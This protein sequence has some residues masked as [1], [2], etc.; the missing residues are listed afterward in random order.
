M[1]GEIEFFLLKIQVRDA[2][3][4]VDILRILLKNDLVLINRLFG[5]FVIVRSIG[6]RDVLLGKRSGKVEPGVDQRRVESYR[7][8]KVIDRL[9]VFGIFV[10][11]HALVQVIARL[12]LGATGSGEECQSSG[13]NPQEPVSRFHCFMNLLATECEN[14]ERHMINIS[15]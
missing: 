1:L 11:L 4:A 9:L 13:K 15:S 5:K 7:L 14:V 12:Q 2:L 10:S 3:D 6:A 8:L